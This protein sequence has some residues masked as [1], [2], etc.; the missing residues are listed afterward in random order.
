MRRL[1]EAMRRTS[2]V[3]QFA[4]VGHPVA[5]SRSPEIFAA[6]S[7]ASGIALSYERL[8]VEPAE[9]AALFAWANAAFDGWNVTAPY[10][11][12]A[13]AAADTV[14]R[15]AAIV[16]AAN[17]VTFR[18]GRSAAANTDVAGVTALFAHAGI[19]PSG[20][21]ATVLGAGGAARAAV[22]ALARGGATSITVVNRTASN[23][24]AL[25]DDLRA[26]AGA[27]VL[28]VGEVDDGS[29][30]VINATSNGAAVTY[31]IG[32]CAPDGWCVDLQYK[33]SPTPF[34]QA[35]RD[36]G[37]PVVDGSYMLVAQALATFRIWFGDVTFAGDVESELTA[38]VEAS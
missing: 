11:T 31:A 36:A 3:K 35:A 28:L 37:R 32:A 22:L 12:L 33:P 21:T 14:T 20:A 6:L 26:P 7:A 10:K 30:I 18:E 19:D 25:V 4:V 34:V 13:I 38:L 8:D 27:T 17:V 16:G 29:S 24:R 23:A 2:G 5:H 9:F 15:D 1:D